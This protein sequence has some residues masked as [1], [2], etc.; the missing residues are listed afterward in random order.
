VPAYVYSIARIREKIDALRSPLAKRAIDSKIFYAMKANRHEGILIDLARDGHVGIDCCSPAEIS[1]ALKSGFRESQ[2]TFTGTG[3]SDADVRVLADHPGV[4]VN[5]DSISQIRK[6]A[7][8]CVGRSIGVRVNTG[9]GVSYGDSEQFSYAGTKATKF[10]VFREQFGEALDVATKGGLRVVGIHCHSG[11]GIANTQL[12]SYA[13]ILR[14]LRT[15]TDRVADLE[16]LN[17]GGGFGVRLK[18]SDAPLDIDRFVSAIDDHFGSLGVPIYFEPGDYV[19]KD[20]G[21]LILQ[22][23]AIETKRDCVF[24]YVNGGHNLNVEAAHYGLTH[25]IVPL[26]LRSGSLSSVTV[27]G[28]INEA[29]DLFAEDIEMPKIEEG[30]F[31]AVLH[32]GGYG[33]SMSSNHCMRGAFTEWLI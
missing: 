3:V 23:T 17:L 6:M 15:F 22:V 14:E 31:V 2:I 21:V 16:Y 33:A 26:T 5:C 32:A 27:A 7:R 1:R 8:A 12:T 13:A 28:N 11:W 24:V 29:I 20:A 18:E 30:D 10:G 4:L 25:P 9:L 19:V